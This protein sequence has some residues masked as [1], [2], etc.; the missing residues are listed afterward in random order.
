MGCSSNGRQADKNTETYIHPGSQIPF[1]HTIGGF[2]RTDVVENQPDHPGT[3]VG[4]YFEK[5]KWDVS[6]DVFVYPAPKNEPLE[7]DAKQDNDEQKPNDLLE[8][9]NII[10][11]EMLEAG[12]DEEH[13]FIAKYDIVIAKGDNP[14]PG[15]RSYF[16]HQDEMFSNSYLFKYGDWFV[17]YRSVF[18]RNLEWH[19][20]Q[21]VKD[22]PWMADEP[23][24]G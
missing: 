21:F 11:Q 14:Y 3:K 23:S 9:M 1:P 4:Y 8:R 6:I 17:E 2:V 16:R 7:D 10:Q 12:T 24:N 13:R 18:D 15:K 19:E 20:D 22:H 5:S